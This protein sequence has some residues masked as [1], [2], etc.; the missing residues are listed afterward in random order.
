M[1]FE[2]WTMIGVNLAFAAMV[3]TQYPF[4]R[5]NINRV[6]DKL[7]SKTESTREEILS[8]REHMAKLEGLL[9]GLRDA[10]AGCRAA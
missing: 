2:I 6:K 3:L 7:E 4:T 5:R 1:T 8:L 10:I 9:D